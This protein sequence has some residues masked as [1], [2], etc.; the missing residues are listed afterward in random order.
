MVSISDMDSFINIPQCGNA[1]SSTTFSSPSTYRTLKLPHSFDKNTE[2]TRNQFAHFEQW[3]L[4]HLEWFR[5]T[6]PIDT[7]PPQ[8]VHAASFISLPKIHEKEGV[9][10]IHSAGSIR[11]L[12]SEEDELY[13]H[14]DHYNLNDA[15]GHMTDIIE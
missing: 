7:T 11:N 3:K 9:R 10:R 2:R 13:G 8:A 6:S 1:I 12:I 14:E 5:R 4:Q 15:R